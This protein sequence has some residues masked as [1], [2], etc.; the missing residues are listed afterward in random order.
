[1]SVV[2][3]LRP[4]CKDISGHGNDL[5]SN[6]ALGNVTFGYDPTPGVAPVAIFGGAVNQWLTRA[7]GGAL[8]WA[9]IGAGGDNQIQPAQRG[10]SLGGWFW[11]SA[12]PGVLTCLMAKD[13]GAANRQYRLVIEGANT[14]GFTVW[15][16]A[17][18]AS[19]VATLQVGW[20]HC[21]GIYD[22]TSLDLH[23]VLN[24][25]ATT[26]AGVGPV[27]LADSAAPFTIGAN[28]IGN[29]RFTGRASDCWLS[30]VAQ[31]PGFVK[32]GYHYTKA[33]Y[34]IK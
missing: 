31:R 21:V 8:N 16:G 34:G 33:A 30:A 7:D 11:I 22:Q 13:D 9:D 15:A 12:L 19:S 26:N 6:N 14:L 2:D 32:A 17:I 20:N 23:V 1:M 3:Y 24:G 18:V 25:V 10:V 29:R 4:E 27:L 5:Q 28:G